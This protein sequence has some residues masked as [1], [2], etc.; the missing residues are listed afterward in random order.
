MKEGLEMSVMTNENLPLWKIATKMIINPGEVVKLQMAKVPWPFSLMISGLAFSLFFLQTAL[1]MYRVGKIDETL[2]IVITILGF[3]YGTVGITLLAILA[4]ALAQGG[5]EKYT[6]KWAISAFALGYSATLIYSVIGLIFSL[7]LGWNTAVAFGVTGLLWALRPTI[8]TIR[9]M[10]GGKIPF[11][12]AV[13]TL[14][15][16]ILLLGWSLL[17]FFAE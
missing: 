12:I 14:C 4:W 2:L 6:V 9:Q 8:M 17:S 11:S 1:D 10:S 7:T 13:S 5:E 15:G 3:I 16:A